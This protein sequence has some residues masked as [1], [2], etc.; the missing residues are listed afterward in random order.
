MPR[1]SVSQFHARLVSGADAEPL[2]RAYRE[3]GRRTDLRHRAARGEWIPWGA[4]QAA[5][6]DWIPWGA[7]PALR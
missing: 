2:V 4:A 1:M 3:M 6:G 7:A 5:R